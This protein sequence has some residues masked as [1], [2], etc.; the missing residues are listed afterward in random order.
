VIY[1]RAGA[2]AYIST[3]E[4]TA[5]NGIDGVTNTDGIDVSNLNLGPLFPQGVFVVQDGTNDGSNQNFKLVPWQSIVNV[6]TPALAID[7]AWN[8]PWQP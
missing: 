4:I 8:S 2:N 7:T 5:A 3:F 6:V 1:Q